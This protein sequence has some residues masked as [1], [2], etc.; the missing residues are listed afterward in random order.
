[1]KR[2]LNSQLIRFFLTGILNTVFGYLIFFLFIFI[3]LHYSIAVLLGTTIGALFNFKTI[4]TFVFKSRDNSLVWRFIFVYAAIYI[5]NV[6]CLTLLRTHIQSDY[7]GQALI[8]PI[9]A[10]AS[11][12]LNK[13]FVFKTSALDVS[14]V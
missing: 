3:G 4:G 10:L 11:F 8:T 13:K 9:I 1:M 14:S 5:F 2:L 12:F 6:I 7:L